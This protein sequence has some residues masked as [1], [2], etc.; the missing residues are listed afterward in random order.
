MIHSGYI[1]IVQ[2]QANREEIKQSREEITQLKASLAF[3]EARGNQA[4]SDMLEARADSAN[5]K[6]QLETSEATCLELQ[7]NL[8][9]RAGS[10]VPQ[11]L[12]SS[13][14]ACK[15]LQENLKLKED[16]LK[17]LEKEL[18]QLQRKSER[19]REMRQKLVESQHELQ[20][21]PWYKMAEAFTEDSCI[22]LTG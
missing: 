11:Q 8:G 20:V 15:D 7:R 4:V 9:L 10:V 18:Q 14:S 19:R 22:G 2:L 13:A 6:R 16:L 17:K 21:G 12:E 3:Q 5:A 1:P